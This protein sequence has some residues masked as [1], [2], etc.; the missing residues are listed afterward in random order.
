M[1]DKAPPPNKPEPPRT[2]QGSTLS[3]LKGLIKDPRAAP[4][5]IYA[6]LFFMPMSMGF[7]G[8]LALVLIYLNQDDATELTKSHYIF[9]KNTFWY[10]IGAIIACLLLGVIGIP[11]LPVAIFVVSFLW[12]VIR[13][14]I[15]YNHLLRMRPHPEPNTLLA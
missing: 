1:P 4:M 11:Y 15:G 10:G 12:I 9:Q 14:T 3:Q 8:V 6:L 5:L 7:A 13:A 2:A